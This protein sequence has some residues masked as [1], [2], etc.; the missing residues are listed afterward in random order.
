MTADGGNFIDA[1]IAET[2]IAGF[3]RIHGLMS[4]QGGASCFVRNAGFI[5]RERRAYARN[6]EPFCG[7]PL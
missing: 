7:I 1:E 6:A 3:R 2:T 4:F 5:P